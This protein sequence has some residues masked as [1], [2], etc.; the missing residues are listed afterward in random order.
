MTVVTSIEHIAKIELP[1]KRFC[2]FC[3]QDMPYRSKHCKECERCVRK[4]DH[5]C[6]WVG[7]CVGELNHRKFWLFLF[8]QT[9]HF[10]LCFGIVSDLNVIFI[11]LKW[12]RIQVL[13]L[14]KRTGR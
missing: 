4:Y 6:F 5:H 3:S 11:G 10:F 12:T 14:I 9:Y 7:G 13:I 2:D 8:F 1:K